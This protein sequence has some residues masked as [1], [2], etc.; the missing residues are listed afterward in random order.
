MGH[1][2]GEVGKSFNDSWVRVVPLFWLGYAIGVRDWG[3]RTRLGY[4]IA[5]RACHIAKAAPVGRGNQSWTAAAAAE[6]DCFWR[7]RERV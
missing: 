5:P 1:A 4:A 6:A 7:E 2:G 3:I